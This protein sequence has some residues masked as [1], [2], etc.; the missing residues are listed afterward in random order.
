MPNGEV[1]PFKHPLV[2]NLVMFTGEAVLLAIYKLYQLRDRQLAILQRSTELN[3]LRFAIPAS[4][5]VMGSFLN[6]TGLALISASSYQ[7]LKMLQ[8][9]F[10]VILSIAFF[11]RRY[12]GN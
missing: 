6:F 4:L 1:H 11:R 9:I 7:I 8:L 3:P 2:F 10:V 12:T 5:D